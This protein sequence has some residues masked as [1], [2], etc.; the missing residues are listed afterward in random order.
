MHALLLQLSHTLPCITSIPADH[1]GALESLNIYPL[2]IPWIFLWF[3]FLP[4]I[5]AFLQLI[6]PSFGLLIY[7]QSH[8]YFSWPLASILITCPNYKSLYTWF[9]WYK[10][11]SNHFSTYVQVYMSRTPENILHA[12]GLTKTLEKAAK[13]TSTLPLNIDTFK[14]ISR[15]ESFTLYNSKNVDTINWKWFTNWMQCLNTKHFTVMFLF[16]SF[17]NHVIHYLFKLQC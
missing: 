2:I 5:L 13:K 17:S 11:N 16:S 12:K 14:D 9:C 8:C 3:H 10:I 7:F 1:I 4:L 15:S 6:H